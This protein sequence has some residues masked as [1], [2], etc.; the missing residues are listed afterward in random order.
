MNEYMFFKMAITYQ[1]SWREVFDFQLVNM[2]RSIETQELNDPY[3][4]T[5]E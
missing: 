2:L 3:H 1:L 5:T 4:L